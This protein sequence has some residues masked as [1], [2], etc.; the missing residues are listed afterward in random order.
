MNYSQKIARAFEIADY[1]LL[2]PALFG[3]LAATF[4]FNFFTM[5]IYAIFIFGCVLL[6]GYFKHSRGRLAE[7]H[8]RSL[9]TA[10]AIYNAVLLVPVLIYIFSFFNSYTFYNTDWWKPFTVALSIAFGYLTAI[11]LS[12]R[13]YR[14]EKNN[15]KYL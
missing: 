3:A 11:I 10:T 14:F 7:K 2:A 4:V 8:I 5:L 12:V 6:A 1:I 13:A 9:W 15:Q